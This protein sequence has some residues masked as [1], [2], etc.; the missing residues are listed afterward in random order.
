MEIE[1]IV[2][3]LNRRFAEPLPDF[4]RRRI[5]VWKDEAQEFSD[6]LGDIVLDGAKLV[7]LTGHN[8]FDVKK[9]LCAD[10]KTSNYVLYCPIDYKQPDDNWLLDIELYSE[11]FR[12]DLL[13]IWME[14]LSIPQTPEMRKQVRGYQKFFNA[15]ERRARLARVK[16]GLDSSQKLHLAVM[17]ALCG[18]Q[19]ASPNAILRAVLTAGFDAEQNAI[20]QSFVTF[21][22]E[23]IFWTMA[24][25]RAGYTEEARELSHLAVHILLTA[26]TRSIRA[27]H[28]AGLESFISSPHQAFCYDLVHEWIHSEQTESIRQIANVVEDEMRLPQRFMGLPADDLADLECFP[29]VNE[30]ILQKLMKDVGNGLIHTSQIATVAEKRRALAWYDDF[31]CYYSAIVQLANMQAF[32]QEHANDFHIVEAS[33]LWRAYTESYYQMDTYYRLFHAAFG[34]SL[35]CYHET[36]NDLMSGVKDAA[37]NLYKNWFLNMLGENWTNAASDELREYGCV[38]DVPKQEDFYEDYVQAADNRI[39]VIVSDAFR[40]E[41][42]AALSEQLRRETQ[43]EIKL[44]TMQA[45]FPT[46]TKFGMAALLPHKELSVELKNGALAVLADGASTESGAR[47]KVLKRANPASVA[48]Q[49]RNVIGMKR[50]ERRALVE[51][52]E[53]VYIYHD[54]VDDASHTTDSMVFPACDQAIEELKSMIRMIVNEFGATNIVITADHGFLY[55]YSPLSEEDKAG[56]DGFD[57]KE[58]EYG[59]RYAILKSGA[60]PQY[61]MPVRL[62]NGKTDYAA[63]AP[64]ENIRI[65]LQGGGLNY[66]HGGTSL[67]EM[68]VPVLEYHFLRNQYKEYQKN[69][70]RYDTKPVAVTLLS[71]NKKISNMIFSLNFYQKDAVGDNREACTYS[72]CFTDA[73]GRKI[74]DEQRII[75]DKTSENSQD[76]T[77]RCSFNLKPLQY[78]NTDTYYLVIADESGLQAPQREE[79]QIDI[80]FAVDEFDFFG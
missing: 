3:E 1:T 23:D 48:L 60:Q 28:L 49:Y 25:R 71:A 66:V 69:K 62:L 5:I 75:A 45:V 40:Y 8:T 76:R 38:S 58:V 13:S 41:L 30:C 10:D 44:S 6:K 57:G 21:G 55:T 43:C 33:G 31:F 4:Y 39:F 63:Y 70:S 12:S 15:K 27:E 32:Y 29:C 68:V 77:F 19:D 9:L 26:A 59:R 73:N 61:L 74:S 37:E 24:A 51:G 54:T 20:Y 78:K 52:Q 7:A 11:E 34:E 53:V 47:D 46:I 35:K 16:G 50:E 18:V 14:E 42:A 2:R 72:V 36:L 79:F 67:Q 65:K 56:K 64:R 17:A 80:A 22:V